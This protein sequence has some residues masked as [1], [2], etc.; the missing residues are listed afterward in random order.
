V[1]TQQPGK[2]V[3]LNRPISPSP[4]IQVSNFD[5]KSSLAVCA[6]LVHNETEEELVE[7]LQGIKRVAIDQNGI[8]SFPKLK[9]TD[10]TTKKQSFAILFTLEE[11]SD[12][13]KKILATIKS[14]SFHTQLRGNMSTRNSKRRSKTFF[15]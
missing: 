15:L 11:Y 5:K 12:G 14:Q 10:V 2:N 1:I 8:V 4:A 7:G 3:P 13:D 9:V 6:S